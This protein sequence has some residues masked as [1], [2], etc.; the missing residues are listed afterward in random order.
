MTVEIP[1]FA[2]LIIYLA[3]LAIFLIFSIFN[4][5]HIFKHDLSPDRIYAL[6]CVYFL[7]S[8]LVVFGTY[9]L[10]KDIDWQS[11]ITV[12][13]EQYKNIKF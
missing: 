12:F 13:S 4:V 1:L 3:Y 9:Y 2:L 5:L 11:T 10:L 7:L 8:A 6:I